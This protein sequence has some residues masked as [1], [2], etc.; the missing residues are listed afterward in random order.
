[1]KMESSKINRLRDT[2]KLEFPLRMRK[3]EKEKISAEMRD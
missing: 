1:M 3:G 2:T